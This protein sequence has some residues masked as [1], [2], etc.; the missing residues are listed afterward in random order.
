MNVDEAAS[1]RATTVLCVRRKNQVALGGDG[2]VTLGEMVLKGNARKIRLLRDG[3]VLAG[4]AGGVAEALT[5]FELFEG[6]LE[7]HQ[8]Q[9][10]RAAVELAKEWRTSKMLRHLEAMLCVAD[11]QHSLIISGKGDVIEPERDV[12]SI[13]SGSGYAAAAARALLENTRQSCRQVVEKA[14][15]IS[16]DLCIY[17][18]HDVCIEELGER[19]PG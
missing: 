10:L 19:K 16:A 8:G 1:L 3:S 4:F 2:Q 5:L 13:G 12:M 17:T 9:L 14:L 18:N 6:K 11:A 15:S 7:M